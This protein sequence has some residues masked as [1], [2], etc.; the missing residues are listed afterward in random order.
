MCDLKDLIRL[1]LTSQGSACPK[2]DELRTLDKRIDQLLLL[3]FDE[4][5]ESREL[6]AQIRI[7]ECRRLARM[8]A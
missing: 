5:T 2:Q 4:Y 7:D 6:M 3:A 8:S 1:V